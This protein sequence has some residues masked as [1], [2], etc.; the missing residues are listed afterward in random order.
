MLFIKLYS[1]EGLPDDFIKSLEKTE[2]D[3]YKI[4]LK[5]PHYFPVMKKCC[6]SETRRKMEFAFNS[7]CKEVCHILTVLCGN[8]RV[9]T[10]R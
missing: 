5:Y 6:I 4:T 8:D 9:E 7:R 1:V 2:E 10:W 3:K